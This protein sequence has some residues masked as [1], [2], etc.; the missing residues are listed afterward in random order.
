MKKFVGWVGIAACIFFALWLSPSKGPVWL[1]LIVAMVTA[2]AVLVF[3]QTLVGIDQIQTLLIEGRPKA[4]LRIVRRRMRYRNG[5][6]ARVPLMIFAAAAH[7]LRG[8]FDQGLSKLEKLRIPADLPEDQRESWLFSY[9]STLFGC[10]LFAEQI[11]EAR[12]TFDQQLK[13]YREQAALAPI[14]DAME[15][16]LHYCEG[17]H[18][19]AE[20]VFEKITGDTKIPPVSRAVFHYFLGRIFSD[21]GQSAKADEQFEM[22]AALAP[23]TWI[24]KGIEA[25]RQEAA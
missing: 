24:P 18:I 7:S 1:V 6:T 5:G 17:E 21:R 2:A 8:D 19:R 15:A 14:I 13:Q 22:A 23:R 16:Q 25:L 20:R 9:A 12:E 3:W 10:L 11:A 4:V